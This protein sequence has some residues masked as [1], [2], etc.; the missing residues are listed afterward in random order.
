MAKCATAYSMLAIEEV[1][2][3]LPATLITNNSPNPVSNISSGTTLLSAQ[4]SIIAYG[5][6]LPT[7]ESLLELFCN[8]PFK[9]SSTNLALPSFNLF[10]LS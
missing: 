7:K 8:F 3:T 6:C 10:K 4:P 1:L 9:W 5:L 2:A